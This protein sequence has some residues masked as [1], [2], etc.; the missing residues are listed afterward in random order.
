MNRATRARISLETLGAELG[1]DRQR[2]H[3]EA[4]LA[5]YPGPQRSTRPAWARDAYE[6]GWLSLADFLRVP[7]E[8]GVWLQL[9]RLYRKDW[10]FAR[11][12]QPGGRTAFGEPIVLV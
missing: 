3:Y 11:Q 6:R 9:R 10:P 2:V 7:V 12:I 8:E 5:V 4:F 1:W